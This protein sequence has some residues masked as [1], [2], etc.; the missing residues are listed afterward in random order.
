MHNFPK[1]FWIFGGPFG[2]A[3]FVLSVGFARMYFHCHWMGDIVAGL[4]Q[5]TGTGVVLHKLGCKAFMKTIWLKVFG[6]PAG[7]GE[8]DGFGGSDD[9]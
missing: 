8:D 5:G 7:M 6:V 3:Q 2:T 4:V 9:L 1:A